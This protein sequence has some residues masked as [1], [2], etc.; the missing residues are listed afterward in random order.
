[1]KRF[2]LIVLAAA[3]FAGTVAAQGI[4][5]LST[6]LSPIEESQKMRNDILRNFIGSVDFI[7][8]DA[9]PFID[10]ITA[11]TA[12]G[13]GTVSLLGTLHGDYP[14]FLAGGA[15][16]PLNDFMGELGGLGF[17]QVFMDL[18]KLGTDNQYYIPWMQATYFMAANVKALPYLPDGADVQALTYSQLGEWAKNIQDATGERLLGF[19]GGGLM[20]RFFQGYL[21]PSYTG[22]VVTE[23]RSAAAETMWN[24]FKAIWSH[25]NPRS[26]TY[27]FMQEPLLAEEVW[28]AFDHTARL[29]D[30]L[31]QRPDDF[32]TFPAPAGPAGRGF[33]PILAGLAIPATSPDV[34]G[35]RE[36]I[37]YLSSPEVQVSVLQAGIGFFPVVATEL[38]DDL[39]RGIQL[40]G[41]AIGA[42][43]GSP[44]AIASLLPVGL[45]ALGGEFNKVFM[46]TFTRIVLRGENVRTVLDQ[47]AVNLQAVMTQSGA[48]CWGPDPA[49]AGPCQVK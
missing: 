28:I 14:N 44:D 39:P 1:M 25:V 21:I 30:A 9:G 36:L 16:Q 8:D 27:A 12:A 47:E 6:Q 23:Y 32:V 40:A 49:S 24:D 10:R 48:A 5:F 26:T 19:P 37:K 45:G 41:A 31:N 34:A 17:Q 3:L 2:T 7:T 18:G 33:M 20:H 42:Q 15:L 43:S 29:L 38:P 11:E 22:G 13:R 46:D 4:V 35:A